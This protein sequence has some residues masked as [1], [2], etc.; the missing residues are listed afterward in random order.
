MMRNTTPSARTVGD[1]RVPH[2]NKSPTRSTGRFVVYTC[3]LPVSVA[4]Q[5]ELL[6]KK[7]CFENTKGHSHWPNALQ[8]FIEEYITPQRDGKPCPHNKWK[9]RQPPQLSERAY[10]LTGIPYIKSEA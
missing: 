10:R 6:R 7:Y 5:E 8:P 9:P 3:M 1:S 2:Y 4:T